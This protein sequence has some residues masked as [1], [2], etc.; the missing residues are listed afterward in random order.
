MAKILSVAHSKAHITRTV[1]SRLRRRAKLN[2]EQLESRRLLAAD[3]V[4][5]YDTEPSIGT[6]TKLK[7]SREDGSQA[8]E[9]RKQARCTISP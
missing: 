5:G 6:E 4:E 7:C 3:L 9:T 2:I 1:E 8:L